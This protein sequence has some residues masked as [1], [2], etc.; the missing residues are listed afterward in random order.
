MI[1]SGIRHFG[2]ETGG[3]DSNLIQ[4]N[5]LADKEA[6]KTTPHAQFVALFALLVCFIDFCLAVFRFVYC[7]FMCLILG[8]RFFVFVFLFVDCVLHLFCLLFV[9]MAVPSTLQYKLYCGVT[10][11]AYVVRNST[12]DM[13]KKSCILFHCC[14]CLTW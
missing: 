2:V 9:V 11:I 3:L 7:W 6:W 14:A 8:L 4:D 10:V 12:M 5:S 1:N 13:R